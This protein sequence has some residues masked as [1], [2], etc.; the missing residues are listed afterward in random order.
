[1]NKGSLLSIAFLL[2]FCLSAFFN[3][4]LLVTLTDKKGFFT[5]E[6]RYR[7]TV[8]LPGAENSKIVLIPLIG[9]IGFSQSNAL[10]YSMVDDLK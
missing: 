5:L 3:I 9:T 7:E 10:V 1:M 6:R 2:L 4:F 8:L